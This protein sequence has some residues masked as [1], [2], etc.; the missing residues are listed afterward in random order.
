MGCFRRAA[1]AHATASGT[2]HMASRARQPVI[3]SEIG[4]STGT[5]VS[6]LRV[7]MLSAMQPV[8]VCQPVGRAAFGVWAGAA[9][10]KPTVTVRAV[11]RDTIYIRLI[12]QKYVRVCL[13]DTRYHCLIFCYAPPL[14]RTSYIGP[15]FELARGA[16]R[17][18]VLSLSA[19]STLLQVAGYMHA[20]R[21]YRG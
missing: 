14:T 16:H 11:Q 9:Q 1:S 4:D 12:Y 21:N 13:P 18:F 20:P 17:G 10:N 3:A 15:I 2:E 5:G 6:A 8:P 19:L 7:A